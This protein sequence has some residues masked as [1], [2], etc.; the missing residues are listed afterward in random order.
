MTDNRTFDYFLCSTNVDKHAKF[1]FRREPGEDWEEVLG[2][3]LNIIQ[4]ATETSDNYP[5]AFCADSNG[6]FSGIVSGFF[7]K[8]FHDIVPYS[9]YSFED[10][11]D[12]LK[13][14]VKALLN[15]VSFPTD[16]ISLQGNAVNFWGKPSLEISHPADPTKT[17]CV[18]AKVVVWTNEVTWRCGHR[19]YQCCLVCPLDD[20]QTALLRK[21]LERF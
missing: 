8:N 12:E 4:K 15:D 13:T 7:D 10:F 6:F 1:F 16:G 3:N 2:N 9:S 19:T 20:T 11:D 5:V 21:I 14:M 18:V 17:Q